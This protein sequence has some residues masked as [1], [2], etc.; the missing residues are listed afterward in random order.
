VKAPEALQYSDRRSAIPG[1]SVRKRLMIKPRYGVTFRAEG[2][3]HTGRGT[4]R[5]S[6]ARRSGRQRPS[7]ASPSGEVGARAERFRGR[8]WETW[9]GADMRRSDGMSSSRP[10]QHRGRPQI[11]YGRPSWSCST[12]QSWRR[13]RRA[14]FSWTCEDRSSRRASTRSLQGPHGFTAGIC[15]LRWPHWARGVAPDPQG[16]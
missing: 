8:R 11:S 15:A 9:T 1:P 6:G 4:L 13:S 3:R 5:L 2:L 12:R 7:G 14:D 10:R 16:R